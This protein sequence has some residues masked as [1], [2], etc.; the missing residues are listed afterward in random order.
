MFIHENKYKK[1]IEAA[2]FEYYDFTPEKLE[3]MLSKDARD[4]LDEELRMAVQIL[5]PDKA[6]CSGLFD[7]VLLFDIKN[8]KRKECPTEAYK[9]LLTAPEGKETLLSRILKIAKENKMKIHE[10]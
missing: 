8:G 4:A 6:I 2:G 3:K 1:K 7:G 5:Y 10:S 9:D